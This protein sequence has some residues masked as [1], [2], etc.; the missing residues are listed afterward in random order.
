LHQHRKIRYLDLA[1]PEDGK[2][3]EHDMKMLK[4]LELQ[5]LRADARTGQKVLHLWDRACIDY[6]FW[7]QAKSQKGIYF[8]TRGKSNSVTK[9]IREHNILDHQARRNEGYEIRQIIYTNP[10]DGVQYRYT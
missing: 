2:K 6:A 3:S 5:A 10:A 1:Q 8:C 9:L 7:S 4:R